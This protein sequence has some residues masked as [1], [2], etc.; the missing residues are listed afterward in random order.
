MNIHSHHVGGLK[1][2]KGDRLTQQGNGKLIV[3][4]MKCIDAYI[5]SHNVIYTILYTSTSHSAQMPN[6]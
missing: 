5:L 4:L 6:S 3:V 1:P 2:D